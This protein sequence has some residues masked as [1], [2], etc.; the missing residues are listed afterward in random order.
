M[1]NTVVK[2]AIG[3]V[4]LAVSFLVGG[5]ASTRGPVVM[6][7]PE[8]TEN[9]ILPPPPAT[10]KVKYLYSVKAPKEQ[11]KE[12]KTG[13]FAGLDWKGEDTEEPQRF[14]S[15]IAA[16]EVSKGLF[17]A[18]DQAN[19]M[20]LA[21]EPDTKNWRFIELSVGEPL[22]SLVGIAVDDS[23][24]VYL[25]DSVLKK[26]FRLRNGGGTAETFAADHNFDRPTG[27]VFNPANKL[28]YVVDTLANKV[29]AFDLAGKKALEFGR[30]G[31]GEGEFNYPTFMAAD[32]QGN[33]FVTDTM[34]FRVQSFTA[35]G[36]YRFAFG[37]LGD[38]PGQ[39]SAPKGVSVGPDGLIYVVDGRQDRVQ[40]FSP[41]GEFLF[42]FGSSGTAPGLFWLANGIY[43]DEKDRVYVCDYMNNRVQVFQHLGEKL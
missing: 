6:I 41:K 3:I 27:I 39:F 18:V 32:R 43:V 16:A 13:I 38:D 40:A 34:N 2:T 29:V 7:G 4:F 11:P 42:E 12:Q 1:K 35:E 26:V 31:G 36:T 17:Y 33:I 22:C 10:S 21:F 20:L 19:S 25:T 8:T 14:K 15:P 9:I 5:C 23:G 37:S 30:R 24:G 28:I